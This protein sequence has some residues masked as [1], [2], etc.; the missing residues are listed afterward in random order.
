MFFS[1]NDYCLTFLRELRWK[2]LRVVGLS[3]L[4]NQGGAFTHTPTHGG[5][6]EVGPCTQLF[7]TIPLTGWFPWTTR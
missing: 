2:G 3:A 6:S 4:K 5:Q 7:C 1:H